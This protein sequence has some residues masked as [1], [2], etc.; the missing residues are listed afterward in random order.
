MYIHNCVQIMFKMW[1][2]QLSCLIFYSVL[3]I[4]CRVSF[5]RKCCRGARI[6]FRTEDS[7]QEMKKTLQ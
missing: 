4:G 3:S 2:I 1:Y 7:S 5:K 6:T